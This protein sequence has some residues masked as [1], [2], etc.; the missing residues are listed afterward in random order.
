MLQRCS[1]GTRKVGV[2]GEMAKWGIGIRIRDKGKRKVSLLPTPEP[3]PSLG[4][5]RLSNLA[6]FALLAWTL[7]FTFDFSFSPS[8]LQPEAY[9]P[10]THS[11]NRSTVSSRLVFVG[12]CDVKV[13]GFR[14]QA[15]LALVGHGYMVLPRSTSSPVCQLLNLCALS[16]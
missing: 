9:K 15:D 12:S 5:T 16:A 1:G 13:I 14:Q 2:K 10:S 4:L 7:A 3:Q 8:S 11:D 6:V